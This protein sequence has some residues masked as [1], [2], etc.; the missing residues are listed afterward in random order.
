LREK[1]RAWVEKV[2]KHEASENDLVQDV[3]NLD[4]GAED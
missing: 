1:V 4:V 2:R 3:F